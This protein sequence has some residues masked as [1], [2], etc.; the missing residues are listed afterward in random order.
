M[1]RSLAAVRARPRVSVQ[2][3]GSQH[4]SYELDVDAIRTA[5]E[6]LGLTRP[7]VIGFSLSARWDGLYTPNGG[8]HRVSVNALG[9]GMAASRTLWHELEH[10]RQHESGE[11]DPAGTTHLR[12]RAYRDHPNEVAARRRESMHLILPLAYDV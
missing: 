2:P 12:G 5:C 3:A 9:S 4:A 8:A 11:R 6:Q 10:A 7:V 1:S